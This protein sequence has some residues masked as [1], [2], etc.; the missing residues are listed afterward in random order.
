[1]LSNM[2]KELNLFLD[3]SQVVIIPWLLAIAAL[4]IFSVINWITGSYFNVLG[5]Y[6]R[7]FWGLV[8]ILFSPF[9]HQNFNH[10]FFNTIPL[11]ALGLVLL[12]FGM[13]LFAWVSLCVILVGGGLVWLFGRRALHIGASGLV[14]GYFGFI[15]VAAYFQPSVTT[16]VAAGVVL[17]YFGGIFFGIFPKEEKVSWE[18]HLYGFLSGVMSAAVLHEPSCARFIATH[19]PWTLHQ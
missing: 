3:Q 11:F 15:V 17:Y 6:P 13:G 12:S 7:H 4:W 8:G 14:S 2:I 10:L 19:L 9:L 1:M 16:I 18:S 5:I